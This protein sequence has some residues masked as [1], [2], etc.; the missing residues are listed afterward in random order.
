MIAVV[1]LAVFATAV[2]LFAAAILAGRPEAR[3]AA[4]R[5]RGRS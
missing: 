5:R 3:H 4:R 2:V 1:V